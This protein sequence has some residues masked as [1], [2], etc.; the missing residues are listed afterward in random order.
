MC[1]I[2]FVAIREDGMPGGR[3]KSIGPVQVTTVFF[4]SESRP[5]SIPSPFPRSTSRVSTRCA[6]RTCMHGD[7]PSTIVSE[8]IRTR[9]PRSLN[10]LISLA[11]CLRF[12][13]TARLNAPSCHS[14]H[15]LS[16]SLIIS[17][18]LG[19]FIFPACARAPS[20]RALNSHIEQNALL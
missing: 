3:N 6:I 20:E 17:L 8:R 18:C 14:S 11:E 12:K 5:S 2:F 15:S 7:V 13:A 19:S 4:S 16:I 1:V 9:R 10:T